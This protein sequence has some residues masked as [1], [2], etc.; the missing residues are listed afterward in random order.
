MV[1]LFDMCCYPLILIETH[2]YV[3]EKRKKNKKKLENN[4]RNHKIEKWK[5]THYP[6]MDK[7][8]YLT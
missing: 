1:I 4:N 7:E 6:W 8:S 5:R 2:F 3:S